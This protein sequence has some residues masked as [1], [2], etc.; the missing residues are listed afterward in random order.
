MPVCRV[1]CIVAVALAIT[2]PLGAQ[3]RAVNLT[4]KP[5]AALV[6]RQDP[7]D[8]LRYLEKYAR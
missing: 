8:D 6:A 4:G 2:A 1:Q 7:E 3:G 5:L